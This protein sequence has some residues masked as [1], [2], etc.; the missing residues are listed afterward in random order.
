MGILYKHFHFRLL[1]LSFIILSSCSPTDT[2]N[3]ELIEILNEGL[4][5]SS[6]NIDN[7]SKAL[8]RLIETKLLD[9]KFSAQALLWYPVASKIQ[10]HSDDMCSYIDSLKNDL[11]HHPDLFKS[12]EKENE[13]FN[14]LFNLRQNLLQLNPEI[15]SVF[16]KKLLLIGK[17][18]DFQNS[19]QKDSDRIFFKHLTKETSLSFLNRFQNNIRI[20]ENDLAGFCY[21]KIDTT[22]GDYDSYTLLIT[23]STNDV[24]PGEDIQLLVGVGILSKASKPKI[25]IDGQEKPI[26]ENGAVN[27]T[28]KA[29]NTPGSHTIPIKVYYTNME[30]MT[31]SSSQIVEYNV[32]KK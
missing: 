4:V 21:S 25:F 14:R 10:F 30:G 7:E 2:E 26:E 16:N 27:Y 29:S 23:Q 22:P 9:P 15:K 13:L 32:T 3:S 31:Q 19:N 8:Y 6:T 11:N 12:K 18:F 5:N 24:S 17:P 1:I 20:A 28:Y